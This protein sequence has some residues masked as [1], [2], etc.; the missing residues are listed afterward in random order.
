MYKVEEEM[1]CIGIWYTAYSS[2]K[3]DKQGIHF[4]NLSFPFFSQNRSPS[5]AS[6]LFYAYSMRIYV[7][8]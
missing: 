7:V 4:A 8:H 5:F 3:K 6:V 1:Y 2:S